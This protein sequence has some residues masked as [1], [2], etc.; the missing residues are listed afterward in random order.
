MDALV[1]QRR[2][3]Q[4]VATGVAI[5]TL[6]CG[7]ALSAFTVSELA[8]TLYLLA[9][10]FASRTRH[11]DI[12]IGAAML[13]TLTHLWPTLSSFWHGPITGTVSSLK[14]GVGQLLWSSLYWMAAALLIWDPRRRNLGIEQIHEAFAHAPT[15]TALVDRSGTSCTPTTHS[16]RSQDTPASI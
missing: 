5:A 14:V 6:V 13:A 16:R 8:A 4:P 12:V 3:E 15:P 7:V 9:M 10:L 2:L 1:A 11:R